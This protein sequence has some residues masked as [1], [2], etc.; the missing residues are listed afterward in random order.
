MK[1]DILFLDIAATTH[2]PARYSHPE[3]IK[4]DRPQDLY[5]PFVDGPHSS[6]LGKVVIAGLGAQLRVLGKLEGR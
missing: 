1:R 4:L 6:L 3:Q 2:D 5:L